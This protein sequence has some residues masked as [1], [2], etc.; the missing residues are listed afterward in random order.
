M[1]EFTGSE[2]RGIRDPPVLNALGTV[3]AAVDLT[4]LPLFA[5]CQDYNFQL[6][7]KSLTT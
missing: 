5:E 6:T 1:S 3:E 7:I 4:Y 2:L